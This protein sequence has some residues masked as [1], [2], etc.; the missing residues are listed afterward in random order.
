MVIPPCLS[1]GGL[2]WGEERAEAKL[3]NVLVKGKQDRMKDQKGTL[4]DL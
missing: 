1:V 3:T 4:M 2:H